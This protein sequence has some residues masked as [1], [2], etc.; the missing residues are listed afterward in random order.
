MLSHRTTEANESKAFNQLWE[1]YGN[2]QAIADAPAEEELP[3]EQAIRDEEQAILWRAI[4]RIPATYRE[5]LVMFYREQKSIAH[6]AAALELNEDAVKQRLTRGRRLLQEADH[7]VEGLVGVM[8]QHVLL[9]DRREH[10]ALVVL[11]P[12]RDARGEGRPHQVLP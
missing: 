3:G 7:H 12:F 11:H 1:R 4:G 2:W 9:P 5:P 6:V 8:Q 10:V